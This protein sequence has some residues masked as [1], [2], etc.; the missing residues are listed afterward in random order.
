MPRNGRQ[1]FHD[2]SCRYKATLRV[3]AE[4]YGR[5]HK[6][7][8]TRAEVQVNAGGALCSRCDLPIVPGTPWDLDHADHG[9]GYLGASH[10]SYNRAAPNINRRLQNEARRRW[11]E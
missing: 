3:D 8:R 9:G 4:L 6:R 5:D 10:A 7:R 2:A 1:R 11:Y